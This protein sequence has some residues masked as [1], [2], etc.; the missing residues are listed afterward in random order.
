MSRQNS[1][2]LSLV[3]PINNEETFISRSPDV[4]PPDYNDYD[5]ESPIYYASHSP[6]HFPPRSPDVP[7]PGFLAENTESRHHVSASRRCSICRQSGHNRRACPSASVT[8]FSE[9]AV[10]NGNVNASRRCSICR[11]AGHN[12]R[13]CPTLPSVSAP[14]SE[15]QQRMRLRRIIKAFLE[16]SYPND[17]WRRELQW[18]AVF[19]TYVSSL[20]LAQV[21]EGIL[22]PIPIIRDVI[23][24]IY[25]ISHPEYSYSAAP[26]IFL[27]KDY[28]KRISLVLD[29]SC[30]ETI[31]VTECYICCEE[32]CSLKTS[33]GHEFCGTCVSN[34]IEAAKNTTS[35]PVCSY[36]RVPF[37]CLTTSES[38]VHASLNVFIKNL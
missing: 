3:Y 38:S 16:F 7:P 25:R 11:Q 24:I 27:G 14:P 26:A 17:D 19:G 29:I 2:F 18:I 8:M 33:C 12:R 5:T 9:N 21:E 32:K 23:R 10:D 28:A 6:I 36:C 35:A 30:E 34:I 37:T 1:N 22:N 13:A 20:T 15:G 4:P 31:G